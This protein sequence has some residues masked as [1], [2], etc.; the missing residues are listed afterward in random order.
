MNYICIKLVTGEE[1]V[2]ITESDLNDEFINMESPVE[3]SSGYDAQGNYGLKFGMFMSYSDEKLF[4][5]KRKDIILYCKPNNSMIR[6]YEEFIN[7]YKRL[8]E[9]EEDEMNI[10]SF[11]LKSFSIH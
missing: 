3:V 4:T 2:G 11:D 6:Y 9:E 1:L 7:K 10:D 8:D 5:F